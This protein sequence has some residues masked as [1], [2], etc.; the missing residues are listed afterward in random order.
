MAE[1]A[2]LTGAS[3]PLPPGA[4]PSGS[5]PYVDD[6]LVWRDKPWA[7]AF[8]I[9]LA[10]ICLLAF[11]Y[12]TFAISTDAISANGTGTNSSP[13]P[14]DLNAD[15]VIRCV[16]VAI[17]AG[18][19]TSYIM[20]S[21]L[22]WLGAALIRASFI[23]SIASTALIGAGLMGLGLVAPAAVLFFMS[24][25][26]TAYYFCVRRRIPFAAA[27]LAVSSAAL[28]GAP[29]VLALS[30]FLLLVQAVWSLLWAFA[31]LGV[32]FLLNNNGGKPGAGGS[33][34]NSSGTGA[35]GTTATFFMLLSFFWGNGVVRNV[36]AFSSASVVGD[37]WYKGDSA[38]A[39][40]WGAVRRAFTTSFG[41]ISLGAFL[42]ALC[43]ALRYMKA[44]AEESAKK[45]G[46]DSAAL[47][48]VLCLVSCLLFL[49][50]A[51]IE[52]AN[53]WAIVYAA[54]TGLAFKP[55]G[56]AAVQL[57]KE[58]GWDEILNADL[59]HGALSVAG[60]VSAAVGAIAGGGLAWTLDKGP[61]KAS[62][63]AIAAFLCFFVGLSFA[64]V[65]G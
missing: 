36:S 24:A 20:M 51:V 46:R 59:V 25:L 4:L 19:V 50:T 31:V 10:V 56:L 13:Q 11:G 38:K 34:D 44:A 49:L 21:V 63:A 23:F 16:T 42:V 65:R 28:R 26:T 22:R 61:E 48:L 30:F 12:G 32:E 17:V 39:P 1:S 2:L 7:I 57:F 8:Y 35:G 45:S 9:H 62:H 64:M 14:Y 15:V 52:W 29:G 6:S 53:R 3:K 60:F 58:R 43:A 5:L 37:F 55:A 47:T 33:Q 54:L 18:V 40:V 27:H 41:T